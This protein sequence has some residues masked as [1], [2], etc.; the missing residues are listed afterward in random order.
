MC[1][2]LPFTGWKEIDGFDLEG[3]TFSE[4]LPYSLSLTVFHYFTGNTAVASKGVAEP[5]TL[6][7]T[8]AER[9]YSKESKMRFFGTQARKEIQRE[10]VTWVD[11][12]ASALAKIVEWILEDRLDWEIGHNRTQRSVNF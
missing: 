5:R 9:T 3:L 12:L 4:C 1:A 11:L 8:Y 2:I 10:F 6:T 7:N